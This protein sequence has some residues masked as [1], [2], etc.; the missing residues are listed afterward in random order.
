MVASAAEN[1]ESLPDWGYLS[2]TA[3]KIAKLGRT[4]CEQARALNQQQLSYDAVKALAYGLPEQKAVTWACASAERVANPANTADGE[5]LHAAKQW[6][7][8]PTP[9]GQKAAAEAAAKTGF[10]TPAAWAAQSAAWAGS[11]AGLT[12]Q[13]VVGAVMLAAAQAGKPIPASGG[14]LPPSP[15][16]KAPAIDPGLV[17][18]MKMPVQKLPATSLTEISQVP[19]MGPDGLS[20]TLEQRREMAKNVEPFLDLGCDVGQGKGPWGSSGLMGGLP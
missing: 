17:T 12:A 13:A 9:E 11:G 1:S 3:R 14:I 19:D 4:P 7:M 15:S 16:L 6:A 18:D 5:A 8:N 10:Q 2:P 20:L